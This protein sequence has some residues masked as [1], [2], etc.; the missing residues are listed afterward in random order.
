MVLSRQLRSFLGLR[1]SKE[2]V[3]QE[4]SLQKPTDGSLVCYSMVNIKWLL[5]IIWRWIHMH[6]KLS[7]ATL[8]L[9]LGQKLSHHNLRWTVSWKMQGKY[10]WAIWQARKRWLI[11]GPRKHRLSQ[12]NKILLMRAL[13]RVLRRGVALWGQW[14]R[15][16]GLSYYPV[17]NSESSK[18]RW[19]SGGKE[20]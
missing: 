4:T 8:F 7:P 2:F 6:V 16:S 5:M 17:L 19:F 14:I 11:D 9:S 13:I 3:I 10:S 20:G 18:W 12:A 15:K 1:L